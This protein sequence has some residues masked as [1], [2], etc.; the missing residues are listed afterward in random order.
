MAPIEES[1]VEY[2]N[3]DSLLM[4]RIEVRCAACGSH[5]G[6][7]FDDGP[8][9]A[10]K[11]YCIN[12]LALDSKPAGGPAGPEI[13]PKPQPSPASKA[14]SKDKSAKSQKTEIAT[15][16]AGCFWGVEDKFS[17]V[18]GVISTRVGYTGGKVENPTYRMVC[19]DRTGHAESIEIVFDPSVVS[20]TRL[21]EY[22]FDFHDPTQINRQGP[23]IGT[24]YR[25]VIFYHSDEQKEAALKMIR[26][27]KNSGKYRQ[28]IATQVVPASKFYQAEDYHQQYHEKLRGDR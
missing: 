7:V 3:D 23:D 26:S 18:K 4:K 11:H 20:Y 16:A 19:S 15:F 14:G 13:R 24:Q 25:S 12:S 27:L 22:F 5:L 6:H 17:K 9:P 28:P 2:H 21:L 10:H 1:H 8:A